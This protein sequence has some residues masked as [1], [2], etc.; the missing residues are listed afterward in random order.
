MRRTIILI[1]LSTT[2]SLLLLMLYISSL[3]Q[4]IPSET[5]PPPTIL[6]CPTDDCPEKLYQFLA[7][8]TA[9]IH[10]A[11][12]E[13]NDYESLN[14]IQ[15][16]VNNGLDVR[17]VVDADN[18]D[19][20][21]IENKDNDNVVKADTSRAFMHNK[22]CILDKSVVWTGSF[23]PTEGGQENDNHVLIIN[24][25]YLARN[26]EEEFDEL[27]Q[28]T[29]GRGKKTS[30]PRLIVNNALF[31]NYF[32]PDDCGDKGKGGINRVVQLINDAQGSIE[33]AMFA[34]TADSVTEALVRAQQRGV[35][36]TVLVEKR[37]VHLLGSEVQRLK[38]QGITVLVDGNPQIMHHKFM[39][40]DDTI[41]LLGSFNFSENANA[42]NDENMII[43]HDASVAQRFLQEFERLLRSSE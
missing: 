26:Y 11:F 41:V 42:R 22:F 36:I 28:G 34:F 31:E 13:I 23:N 40:I 16:K 37:N 32:C 10:C 33:I 9:S 27:W 14:L 7:V 24:S 21:A 39:I 5:I 1:T 25:T 38:E 43:F 4:Q 19:T 2:V 18:L 29:F 20:L 17:L 3:Y 8:A 30:Y 6:F 15:S 35:S 12:F